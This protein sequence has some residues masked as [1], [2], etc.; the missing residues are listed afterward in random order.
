M[1]GVDQSFADWLPPLPAALARTDG[2][3][4]RARD[5]RGHRFALPTLPKQAIQ[6][7]V[8]D[9]IRPRAAF[10]VHQMTTPPNGWNESIR[11]HGVTVKARIG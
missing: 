1:D 9:E 3:T 5:H 10:G 4:N 8:S 11:S 7:G 6:A 2:V